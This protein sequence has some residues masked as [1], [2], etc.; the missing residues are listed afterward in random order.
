MATDDNNT[1]SGTASSGPARVR[2]GDWEQYEP[3]T[4]KRRVPLQWAIGKF[5]GVWDA[6]A[7]MI[8]CPFPDHQD[9][10]PSFN[11]WSPN[12]EGLPMRYGCFGC[13]AQG[14]V[15]TLVMF[16]RGVSFPEACRIAVEE[17]AP[18]IETSGWKPSEAVIQRHN[19]S[20]VQLQK[21]LEAFGPLTAAGFD[22]LLQFMR[23][24]GLDGE[25]IE[26]YAVEEWGWGGMVEL[27]PTVYMPH[28]NA[29][30]ELTGIKYR[31]SRSD[32]RWNEDG[33]SFPSLYGAWR[34]QGRENVFLAEGETDTIRAAYDLRDL[35]F[36]VFG[37][38][39]GAN[40]K[41]TEAMR[42]QL[43]GRTVYLCGDGDKAGYTANR[44]WYESGIATFI[45]RMPEGEDIL[46]ARIPVP[47]L[48]R[49]RSFQPRDMTAQIVVDATKF[50]RKGGMDERT[51]EAKPDV[52]IAD[53]RFVPERE[54]LTED[55]P[56]WEGHITG[57]RDSVLLRTQDLNDTRGLTRWAGEH[58]ARSFTGTQKDVQCIRNWIGSQADYLPL[59]R[60]TT[61]AGRISRSFVGPD[62]CIGPDRMRY[63]APSAGNARLAERLTIREG[64][65]DP[66]ALRAL[67]QLNDPGTMAVIIGWLVASLL[68]GKRAPAPPLFIAGESG[69]GKTHLVESLLHSFGFHIEANLTT[70][71]PFGVDSFVSSTIGFPVWFDEYRSGARDDSM[72]RLRQIL[73]DAYN[74]QSSVKGGMKTQVTEL[75]EVSTWAGIVV[76]G[77][78]GTSETSLRDR[79]VYITLNPDGRQ[80]APYQWLRDDPARTYGLGHTLLTYLASRNT[81][82]FR[83]PEVGGGDV[84]DRFRQTMG[85]V[86]AGWDAW[87]GFRAT[88]G[89][90]D[91]PTPPNFRSMMESRAEQADPYLEALRHCEGKRVPGGDAPMLETV[92]EEG[93]VG[94]R[95]IPAEVVK[96][97]AAAGITLPG[98]S[99]ELTAW[100]KRR[101]PG[102]TQSTRIG[103]RR[104]W[105]VPGLNLDE[106]ST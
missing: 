61:K 42:Q 36:D 15:I 101:Y 90:I 98:R 45:V 40:Q 13:T 21:T 99:Q 100:L 20:P 53:F 31:S 73:R 8:A 92:T 38:P 96:E 55:G 23:R 28:R 54:L 69:A 51:H 46:S 75:S 68:R 34:D 62:F 88:Q 24:K 97:A 74:G 103:G 78:M 11:L 10:T 64:S 14:D 41:P 65:F 30:G 71:T 63:I 105:W 2:Y 4:I 85:F 58:G 86:Q 37:L 94:V 35:A 3:D 60:A 1:T 29:A 76:S 50:L 32:S 5:F 12:D 67:E 93:V 91:T 39:S 102:T 104:A 77:E 18:E 48:I 47:E 43:R 66:Q 57:T 49:E 16:A 52:A 106:G 9:D 59:E 27:G 82:T 83:I 79:L 22:A 17:L 44:S 80:R 33:S 6:G 95:F 89:I 19:A 87:L 81:A 72:V 25:P 56:A 84:P 7:D 70:T 26:R